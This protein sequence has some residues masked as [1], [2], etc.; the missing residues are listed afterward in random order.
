MPW[1][2]QRPVAKLLGSSG[3]GR[4][5]LGSGGAS[6]LAAWVALSRALA[7]GGAVWFVC[8]SAP[9]KVFR[10]S[11]LSCGVALY[12]SVGVTASSRGPSRVESVA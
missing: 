4:L 3:S 6:L 12:S 7:A 5:H 1:V 9:N 8:P 11:Q 2:G 10:V